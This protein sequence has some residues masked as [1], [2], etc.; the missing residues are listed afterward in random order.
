MDARRG[1]D[2]GS[3]QIGE[4]WAERVSSSNRTDLTKKYGYSKIQKKSQK[5]IE[6]ILAIKDDLY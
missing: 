4:T 6:G 3:S 2:A 1:T 5:S